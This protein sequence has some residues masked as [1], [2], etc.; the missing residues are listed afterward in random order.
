MS[1]DDRREVLHTHYHV[2]IMEGFKLLKSVII[3]S[4]SFKAFILIILF[5]LCLLL[6]TGG[7][8]NDISKTQ[9]EKNIIT[10]YVEQTNDKLENRYGESGDGNESI[11]ES[12]TSTEIQINDIKANI[13]DLG[14]IV[15]EKVISDQVVK[16]TD[17]QGAEMA[18]S[19]DIN[20]HSI[21]QHG[22]KLLDLFVDQENENY[23]AMKSLI[24][25]WNPES[26]Q[27][28]SKA[29]KKYKLA[30][31]ARDPTVKPKD[32]FEEP[33][34]DQIV[35][36]NVQVDRCG[37]E[38]QILAHT[39]VTYTNEDNVNKSI[40]TCSPHSF[41][42][43]AKQKVVSFSFYGNP[44]S[45]QSKERKYFEGIKANLKEMPNHY[46]N[47]TLRLYYDLPEDHY[48]MKD[49]CELACNDPHID[50][51]Y[52]QSIPALGNV[53]QVFPMNWRFLP[54]LDPQVSHMV[55]RDL[56]SLVNDRES[57]A[58]NEWLESDKAFHFM[59]DHP[60]HGI[61]ILG[62]G[63]GVRLAQLERSFVESAFMAALK[64]PMF[65]APRESYGQDQG[66]LKR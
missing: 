52:V 38:R 4:K 11:S 17:P 29:S 15:V 8:D 43:G 48:L 27:W 5:T 50:L 51:C 7:N 53:S 59:R 44:D 14:R 26:S 49:L 23:Q 56:D 28:A 36:R 21:M 37:C 6:Q 9:E 66:F 32:W 34:I 30:L 57:A 61:E 40:G 16:T 25:M 46:P 24:D 33:D 19:P 62:S 55:S 31:R 20:M 39:M 22:V 12:L 18:P 2:N 10:P 13:N 65:W 60:A 1:V 54:M 41:H 47:W 63:W 45:A 58:V 42:R 3:K 64:D 35:S